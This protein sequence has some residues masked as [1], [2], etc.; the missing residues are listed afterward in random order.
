MEHMRDEANDYITFLLH[1]V[2]GLVGKRLY[3]QRCKE[4]LLGTYFTVSD[5]GFLMI[6]LENCMDK[7]LTQVR[8]HPNTIC[9]ILFTNNCYCSIWNNIIFF[10]KGKNLYF[11]CNIEPATHPF[12]C[13]DLNLVG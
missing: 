5:E 1:F 13:N 3:R 10:C 11:R 9:M 6:V 2:P 7:W 12:F 8:R 4:F